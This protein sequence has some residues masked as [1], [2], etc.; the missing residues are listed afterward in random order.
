MN[1]LQSFF[2]DDKHH[3]V[4]VNCHCPLKQYGRI[5]SHTQLRQLADF[6][7]TDKIK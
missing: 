3:T 2:Y 6:A 4:E 7:L 5:A 1:N